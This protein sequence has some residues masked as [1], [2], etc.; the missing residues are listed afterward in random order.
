MEEKSAL[1][2]NKSVGYSIKFIY[3]SLEGFIK[4]LS[5]YKD[6]ITVEYLQSSYK[7]S[8]YHLKEVGLG[9]ILGVFSPDFK[10]DIG[11]TLIDNNRN[12]I[13]IDKKYMITDNKQKCKYYK[14]RCNICG[15]N[16]GEHYKRGSYKDECWTLESS[17]K[18]GTGCCVCCPTPRIAV[19]G[20]NTIWDTDRWMVDLGVTEE[21]A[22]THTSSSGDEIR[23]TC[24]KCGT[25][26]DNPIMIY[27][28]YAKHS[29]GC[30]CSDKTSYP[31]KVMFSVLVQLGVDFTTQL[32]KTTFHWCDIY[33]YDFYIP[34]LNTIIE[35]HGLQH[36]K[37]SSGVF[38]KTLKE[39]Q[40]NDKNKQ[41]LAITNEIKEENYIV[42]DCRKSELE[43]IKQNILQ[44][45]M[46]KIF[47]LSK[48]DWNEIQKYALKNKVKE[49][50]D[51][52]NEET[53]TVKEISIIMKL[54]RNTITKYLKKGN[55]VWCNYNPKEE[56][57]KNNKNKDRAK[58][59][60]KP[61]E[62]FKNN[63]SLGV[64]ESISS[65]ERQ[66]EN[67]FGTKLDSGNISSVCTGK[68]P[69]HKGFTF[70]HVVNL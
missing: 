24:P 63:I 37:D 6:K 28:I 36:Y 53:Y 42:I 40:V 21:D 58:L 15:F 66:S 59:L 1:T 67:K 20:I 55:G 23:I 18:S 9:R 69:Q 51:L 3:G 26:K 11:Q 8:T 52:W 7:I 5:Y 14:Y 19:L 2:W 17:I 34:S 16:C 62:I 65:L 35:T 60:A 57:I 13:I 32:N 38:V 29:I 12:I 54:D 61:V 56:I 39:T 49:A 45:N 47:D 31:E 22:K 64:F 30:E 10:Y 25:A 48:I 43:F 46:S 41:E 50:C 4:V 33:K 70:Q 68:R 27:S 44:S